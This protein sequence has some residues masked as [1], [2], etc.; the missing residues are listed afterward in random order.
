MSDL[1]CFVFHACLELRVILCVGYAGEALSVLIANSRPGHVGVC[2]LAKWRDAIGGQVDV[3]Q[4]E[5]EAVAAHEW[6]RDMHK[7]GLSY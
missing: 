3:V 6:V 2:T 5:A 4:V 7:P 1:C